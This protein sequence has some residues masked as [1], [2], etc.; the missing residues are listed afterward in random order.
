MLY[1][2]NKW[3]LYNKK[4]VQILK[5]KILHGLF[6]FLVV[7]TRDVLIRKEGNHVEYYIISLNLFQ[8]VVWFLKLK[9]SIKVLPWH[10]GSLRSLQI[11]KPLIPILLSWV[12]SSGQKLFLLE[13]PGTVPAYPWILKL[14]FSAQQQNY[15]NEPVTIKSH[16][17]LLLLTSF[18]TASIPSLYT[19]VQTLSDPAG[20]A[21]SSSP[22]LKWQLPAD[23]LICLMLRVL[24]SSILYYLWGNLSFLHEWIVNKTF[25]ISKY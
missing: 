18:P 24:C 25:R 16:F 3:Y 12:K 6:L 14:K 13:G 19:S 23:H 7:F 9:F 10:L 5:M 17:V 20:H 1:F 11:G 4:Q 15:L 2:I 8:D 22:E 21:V